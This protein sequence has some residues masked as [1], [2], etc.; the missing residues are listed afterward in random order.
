MARVE[1]MKR[2]EIC[3][4]IAS[5]KTTLAQ[6]LESKQFVASFE[7]FRSNPFW[8]IFYEDPG[9]Y[10]FE[11]EVTFLLQHYNQI[12]QSIQSSQRA[13]LDTSLVLDLAYADVNLSGA[14][15]GA[16]DSVFSVVSGEVGV[17]N[18]LVHLVCSA[19]TELE[20]IRA[21]NRSEE[22]SITTSYLSQVNDAVAKRVESQSFGVAVLTL[23]SDELDFAHDQEVRET[24]TDSILTRIPELRPESE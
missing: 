13:V 24:V 20:R 22:K 10:S 4:G 12:K 21:R 2:I 5:G 14:Y 8:K 6:L 15:R 9:R 23:D 3:G 11:T 19:E 1:R 16:F 17:P 7:D 18:L